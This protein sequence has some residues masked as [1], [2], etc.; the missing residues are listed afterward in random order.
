[1]PERNKSAGRIRI[2]TWGGDRQHGPL[3]TPLPN[4]PR[5]QEALDTN[6]RVLPSYASGTAAREREDP[7]S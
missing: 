7:A 2:T 1:M 3:P 6:R 5:G 4:A